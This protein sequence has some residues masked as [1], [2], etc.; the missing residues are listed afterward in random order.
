MDELKTERSFDLQATWVIEVLHLSFWHAIHERL[1]NQAM[2]DIQSTGAGIKCLYCILRKLTTY[3]HLSVALSSSSIVD[4][5]ASIS[6]G[7]G[8]GYSPDLKKTVLFGCGRRDSPA[9]FTPLNVDWQGTTCLTLHDKKLSWTD[10][11][12][13]GRYENRRWCDDDNVHD[14]LGHAKG[15]PGAAYVATSVLS[16]DTWND[17]GSALDRV[18][19]WQGTLAATPLD[20]GVGDTLGIAAKF[21]GLT[22]VVPKT[23]TWGWWDD[24][25]SWATTLRYHWSL[26]NCK[27]NF[28]KLYRRRNY[29]WEIIESETAIGIYE[30]ITVM[31]I[32]FEK[33]HLRVPCSSDLYLQL[34]FKYIANFCFIPKLFSEVWQ[35]QMI[36]VK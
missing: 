16:G 29:S 31:G 9:H 34:P 2:A 4:S 15:V 8:R 14:N 35:V 21:D 18:V 3:S 33:S 10:S 22:L 28:W 20:D 24:A 7:I 30:N 17:K 26:L 27:G 23:L 1:Y 11:L 36:L 5:Y 19:W 12:T 32:W 13:G 25:D 6:S